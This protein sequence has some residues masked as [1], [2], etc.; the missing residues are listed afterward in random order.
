LWTN[1]HGCAITAD[2]SL[3]TPAFSNSHDYAVIASYSLAVSVF[4]K[5]DI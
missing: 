1:S 2:Y 5:A 3:A 4:S